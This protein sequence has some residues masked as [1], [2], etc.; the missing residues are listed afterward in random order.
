LGHHDHVH[1]AKP[2]SGRECRASET[3]GHQRIH[4]IILQ[5]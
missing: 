1:A 3:H 2:I 5:I 4:G